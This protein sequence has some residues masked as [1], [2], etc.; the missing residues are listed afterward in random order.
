MLVTHLGSTKGL[1][2]KFGLKR[3]IE[4]L[5]IALNECRGSIKILFENTSGSGFTFGYKLEDI[6]RVINAFGKNNRLGFCFDT[7]HGFAAGYSLKNEEDI[8][9]IIENIRILALN[10]CALFI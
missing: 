2:D 7:C 6:G 1:G 5:S 8:D 10:I 9:T 3:V 4:A